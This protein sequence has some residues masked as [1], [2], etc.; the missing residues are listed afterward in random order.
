MTP[1][2]Q[3]CLACGL[4]CDGTLFDGVQLEPDEDAGQLKALGL[5][6]AFSRAR[7]PVARFAQPCAALCEDRTCQLYQHRPRQ[8]RT[9][10]CTVFKETRA[11]RIEFAAAL[12]LVE[13]TRRQ[14]ERA[15]RLMLRL[16][17]TDVH[18][19]LGERFHR[20]QERLEA[21]APDAAAL[22]LLADLSLAVHRLKLVTQAKFYTKTERPAS[23][24][25]A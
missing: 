9:F 6:V 5:P 18:R 24:P 8:C 14:A 13:K 21:A 7:K 10:E 4:C 1:S 25:T 11:G 20:L 19:S 17:D 12:R 2:E 3:L 23:P 16:G 22:A 15:R